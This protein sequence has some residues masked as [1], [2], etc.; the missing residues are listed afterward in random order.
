MR[1]NSRYLSLALDIRKLSDALISLA[2]DGVESPQ[3]FEAIGRLLAS[4]EGIGQQTSVRALRDRGS[5][6]RYESVVTVNEA[7]NPAQRAELIEKLRSILTP[8]PEDVRRENALEAV[9]FFD[10]LERRALYKYNHPLRAS[11]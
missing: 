8:E 2:E 7:I 1:T 6:G 10:S 3:M 9:S 11:A 4:L 5:F